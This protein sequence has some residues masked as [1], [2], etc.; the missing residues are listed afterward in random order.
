MS[1]KAAKLL[2]YGMFA[3][4]GSYF[5]SGLIN[6]G[7]PTS[8]YQLKPDPKHEIATTMFDSKTGTVYRKKEVGNF[9]IKWVVDIERE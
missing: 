7:A 5:I 8:R 2:M 3:I 6:N 4:A 1:D 9:G